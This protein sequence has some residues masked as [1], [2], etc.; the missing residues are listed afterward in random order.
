VLFRSDIRAV[1]QVPQGLLIDVA[2][3][4]GIVSVPFVE[5]IV[6]RVDR[7]VRQVT[8]DPPAG[9]MEL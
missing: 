2:T 1:Q 4:R 3:A 8:I 7:D 5:P 6:V 9:L